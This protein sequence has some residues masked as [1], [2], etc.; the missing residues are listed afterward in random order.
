MAELPSQI[1]E[2]IDGLTDDLLAPGFMLVSD[3]GELIKWGGALES[4]G[5]S[6][7]EMN[8]QIGDHLA[9]LVG[10]LPLDS[11]SLFLPKVQTNTR[12]FADIYFFRRDQGTWILLLDAT[13]D[14]NKRQALQQRTYD[15]SLRVAELE[16]EGRSLFDAN[17][18]LEHRV[19]EQTAELSETVVRLQEE[20]AE[21]RRTERALNASEARFRNLF[22]SNVIGIVFWDRVGNITEANDA[23]LHL[24]GYSRDDLQQGLLNL[25][26]ITDMDPAA[27]DEVVSANMQ[28]MWGRLR[29]REF[30]RK[31]ESR[32]ALLFGAAPQTGSVGNQVG[33][34]VSLY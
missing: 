7:L 18:N 31:D 28:D 26:R 13:D 12:V 5:I 2:F 20:L 10:V 15:I 8:M 33:F 30:T 21:G 16:H 34:A 32:T 3:S 11:G 22:E 14:V 1:R 6:G 4:H 23:F 17:I 24:L 29:Q 19:G 9:F 25:D 27:T